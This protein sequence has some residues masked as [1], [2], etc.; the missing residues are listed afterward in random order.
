MDVVKN[1][2]KRPPTGWA[3]F[4]ER[5][6]KTR[7]ARGFSRD[8]VAQH[9]S[10]DAVSLFR[11]EK[12]DQWVSPKALQELSAILRAPTASFFGGATQAKPAPDLLRELLATLSTL[13]DS[14]MK[15]ALDAIRG[16]LAHSKGLR[17]ELPDEE[18]EE[19]DVVPEPTR[20]RR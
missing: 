13:N 15:D 19:S 4:G 3:E 18:A 12:G 1:K 20:K 10:V 6:R 17:G 9:T 2:G 5:L 11:I 8:Y 14:E 16:V 7:E